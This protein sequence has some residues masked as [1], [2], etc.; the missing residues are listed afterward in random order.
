[1]RQ[2][3][4]AS[5]LMPAALLAPLAAGWPTDERAPAVVDAPLWLHWPKLTLWLAVEGV[6]I[7][8]ALRGHGGE[9]LNSEPPIAAATAPQLV[10]LC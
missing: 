7:A 6:I 3:A 1:M 8:G 9:R 5:S 10:L 4:A 2:R